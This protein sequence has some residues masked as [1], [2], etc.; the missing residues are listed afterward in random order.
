MLAVKS[1]SSA[2]DFR[3]RTLQIKSNNKET[4]ILYSDCRHYLK[5]WALWKLLV[6]P[7][8]RPLVL[9]SDKSAVI[10]TSSLHHRSQKNEIR[11]SFLHP[12]KS[13]STDS[14]Q[15]LVESSSLAYCEKFVRQNQSFGI[16]AWYPYLRNRLSPLLKTRNHRSLHRLASRSLC[17]KK[18]T[19]SCLV[20]QSQEA[21]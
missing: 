16:L 17:W 18:A 11:S 9:R 15:K 20:N 12:S 4:F 5:P 19:A 3:S 1:H 2:N 14:G 7:S 13:A 10:I 21:C 8:Q 6:T